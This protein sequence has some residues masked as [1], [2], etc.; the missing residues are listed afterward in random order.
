MK[1]TEEVITMNYKR[2]TWITVISFALALTAVGVG[3]PAAGGDDNG[4]IEGLGQ[5]IVKDF[6]AVDFPGPDWILFEKDQKKGG[7]IYKCEGDEGCHFFVLFDGD[8]GCNFQASAGSANECFQGF[9]EKPQG[10]LPPPSEGSYFGFHCEHSALVATFN[11]LLFI[12][13]LC[14]PDFVE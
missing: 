5:L 11:E 2:H 9:V 6:A 4:Q 12:P 13:E 8:I 1:K 3:K 10:P 7:S 14:Y